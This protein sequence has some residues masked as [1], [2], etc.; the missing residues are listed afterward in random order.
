MKYYQTRYLI[1]FAIIL[2]LISSSCWVYTF[3]PSVAGGANS[4]AIAAI[5]NSTAEYGL[6][7]LLIDGLITE[8]ER[9]NTL[10]VVPESQ[11]DLVLSGAIKRY[12]HEPY[13]YDQT[14]T[15]TEYA[16]RF[17]LQIR[18]GYTDSEKILWEDPG[19]TDFGLYSP[20]DGETQADGNQRAADKIINEIMNRT[21]R[22][23]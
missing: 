12:E 5:D 4:I 21:V 1:G 18:I 7:D 19:L 16:C 23:W 13:T 10:K 2:S 3:T 20:G 11:A 17:T 22:G 8:F 6:E 9:D 15:V 14:E